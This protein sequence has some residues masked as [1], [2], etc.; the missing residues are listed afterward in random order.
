MP[1]LKPGRRWIALVTWLLGAA[2]CGI[3]IANS[4]FDTDLAA[5]LPKSP[6]KEQQF[7]IDELRSGILS[8]LILVGIE[9][10]DAS[11]RAT[12]SKET[13][14]L[15]RADP[16]FATINNGEPVNVERDR[17]FYSTAVIF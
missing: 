4:T 1:Q 16:T 5:F 12:L 14:K 2:I 6:T 10:G 3:L 11:T 8:R 9:G 7:L 15:L 17:A 13:A